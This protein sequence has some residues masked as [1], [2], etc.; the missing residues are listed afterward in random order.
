M[1]DAA[2]PRSYLAANREEAESSLL[3]LMRFAT[4]STEGDHRDEIRGAAAW[5]VNHLEG[6]GFDSATVLETGGN[7]SVTARIHHAPGQPILLIY[8][9]YDV[10]PAENEEEWT[11]PPFDPT[12]EDGFIWG[13]GAS[14][15][16][17]QFMAL[18]NGLASYIQTGTPLPLNVTVLIEGEEEINSV[19]LQDLLL[20]NRELLSC[21]AVV[22][23]D[24]L[25]LDRDHPTILLSVRGHAFLELTVTGPRNDLHSGTFGGSVDNPINVLT[26]MLAALQDGTTRKVLIPG[27]YD[28]VAELSGDERKRINELL[29]H[30]GRLV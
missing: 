26:R 18:I 30:R 21:D 7:P 4:V 6:L 27:F 5:L 15:D 17:G 2:T 13:R 23:A 22:A 1:A 19:H 9:H 14:D 12:V 20:R 29:H 28:D 8:G 16:K 24:S 11:R 10:Q 3:E 25:M